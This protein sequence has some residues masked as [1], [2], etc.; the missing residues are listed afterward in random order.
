MAYLLRMEKNKAHKTF[1][2]Y[3]TSIRVVNAVNSL[4]HSMSKPI[5]S[6]KAQSSKSFDNFPDSEF[7]DKK[8]LEKRL[9]G[10]TKSFKKYFSDCKKRFKENLK[11]GQG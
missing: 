5:L 10:Y 2:A 8:A 9:K 4:L 3:K 6:K 1:D 11:K 7:L